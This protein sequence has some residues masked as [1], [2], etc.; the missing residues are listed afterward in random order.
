MAGAG[1]LEKIISLVTSAV[2]ALPGMVATELFHNFA[3]ALRIPIMQIVQAKGWLDPDTYSVMDQYCEDL[4]QK[5]KEGKLHDAIGRDKQIE[6]MMDILT[7]NGKGNPCVVGE[8]G[9][10][11]TA[12]VE[13]L[14]YRIAQGNVPEDFKDKRIIKVN[15]VSLIAGKAYNN[16]AGPVGRMRALFESAKKDPNI[17][18]FI[19]EFHQIVQCNAAE[20]FKTYIDN[21]DI[22]IIT[23]TTK[24]EYDK[25]IT[26]DSA[27]ERRFTK[28]FVEEPNAIETLKMLK[29]IS[30]KFEE[31][32]NV[33]ISEK[34]LISAVELTGRYM[35]N[36]NYPDKAIDVVSSAARAAYR[37]NKC[38]ASPLDFVTLTEKDIQKEVSKA[39]GISIGEMSKYEFESL[40]SLEKR[41]GS[42]I[43]GQDE[44]VKS[45]SDAVRRSRAGMSDS[46]KPCASFLFAGTP[47]VG[48]TALAQ[49]LGSEVGKC[50]KIDLGQEFLKD[51]FTSDIKNG[52]CSVVIFDKLERANVPMLNIISEILENGYIFDGNGQKVDFTNTIVV[53]TTN[54]GSKSILSSTDKDDKVVVKKNV[55]DELNKCLGE[56]FVNQVDDVLVFNKLNSESF[57]DVVKIFINSFERDML[58]QGIKVKV[59]ESVI[60]S[61]SSV[62][63]NH[64]LGSRQAQNIIRERIKKPIANLMLEEKIKQN[65]TVV[66]T[67][68]DG[69]EI[70]F[71]IDSKK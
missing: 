56:S 61:I 67:C 69:K 1:I 63:I 40:R 62:D 27:L 31:D 15:M 51:K 50:I 60:N 4:T 54:I 59:D 47:N 70:E 7:R 26:K 30:S 12:L 6:S 22:K 5:A 32:G 9:V 38:S 10:G 46:S 49:C 13:G 66:C 20:L 43:K 71:K 34:A 2:N 45:V 55:L 36:R 33:H 19:D 16:G 48:K 68:T 39:T 58:K 14:A 41:I 53:I 3:R 29:G 18:L 35:K 8:A 23:A 42:Y 44:A 52:L 24:K 37:E 65:S 25:W 57:K 11:K 64:R 21:G 17:I 28:V